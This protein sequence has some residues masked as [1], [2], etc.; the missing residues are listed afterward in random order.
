MKEKLIPKF[1]EIATLVLDWDWVVDPVPDVYK[2]LEK[3]Q[4]VDFIR[5]GIKFQLQAIESKIGFY[6]E[7]SDLFKGVII[8]DG[9]I[10]H[11]LKV[12]ESKKGF[13]EDLSKNVEGGVIID[14]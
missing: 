9:Y 3:A 4:K 13:Y 11:Q 10:K 1:R 8:T 14:G 12:L 6:K 5:A 7:V 2:V